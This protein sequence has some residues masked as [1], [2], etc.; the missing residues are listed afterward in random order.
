MG[1]DNSYD[2]SLR[3]LQI[4]LVKLQRHVIARG[5]KILIILEGRD[6]AGKDGTIRRIT[7]HLSPRDI[8]VVALPKPSD[9]EA[10]Q[11]YFQRYTPHLPAAGEIVL[12]NRSWYNRAGVEHVMGFCTAQQYHEFLRTA[13]VFESMLA[14]AGITLIKYYLDISRAEQK[15]RLQERREDPLKQWKTSPIDAQALKHFDDYTKARNAMLLAT[16]SAATP[17]IV[18]RADDKK[19]ARLAIIADLI[20][21]VDYED[22]V[23]HETFS[24]I[25]CRFDETCLTNGILAS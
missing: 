13:P 14:E 24:D 17:W 15:E 9:T 7:E 22:A 18:V 25:L 12:F 23:S 2:K 5:R 6:S 19:A 11:W 4:E 16:D 3:H 8:R 20:T 10:T 21:R 1:K